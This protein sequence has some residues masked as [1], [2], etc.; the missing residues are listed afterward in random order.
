MRDSIDTAP[1]CHG[2]TE[3]FFPR[4]SESPRAKTRR[5]IAAKALCDICELSTACLELA[6]KREEYGI[7]GGT[8]EDERSR[9]GYRVPRSGLSR[10]RIAEIRSE[11]ANRA[12]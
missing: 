6:I 1:P 12:S 11:K 3:L 10:Q 9:I 2:K 4:E 7:W 8:N 5:E